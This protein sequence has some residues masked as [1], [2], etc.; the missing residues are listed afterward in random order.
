[1]TTITNIRHQVTAACAGMGP[2]AAGAT[3]PPIRAGN[4]TSG[5]SL[6]RRRGSRM[7]T[8]FGKSIVF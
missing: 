2:V 8:R 6:Y 1:M 5:A 3:M 4:C 7:R